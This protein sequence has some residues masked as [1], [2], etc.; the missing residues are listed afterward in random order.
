MPNFPGVR[1]PLTVKCQ[2]S[3]ANR[4]LSTANTHTDYFLHCRQ[5]LVAWLNNLL[6]LNITKVEQC[7]TGYVT[8]AREHGGA[9]RCSLEADTWATR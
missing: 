9:G 4:Q 2:P 7:G 1:C 6:Q 5:E 8:F 3:T